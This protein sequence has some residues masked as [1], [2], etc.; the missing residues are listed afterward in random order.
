MATIDVE[1]LLA[2]VAS[3]PPCG[4][5]L[6]YDRAF[7]ELERQAAGKPERVMGDQVTPAEEPD[8]KQLG[9]GARALLERTKDLRVAAHLTKAL[10]RTGGLAGF[11]DGMRLV[12][13]LLERYWDGV[14]PR[15][16]PEDGD[17]TIRVNSLAALGDAPTV[18]AL[19]MAALVDA[20]G[21]GRFSLRDLLAATGELPLPAG[22][23]PADIAT[24]EAAFDAAELPDLA[25]TAA[26]VK[27]A[28]EDLAAVEAL[29][30]AKVGAAQAV[31]VAK[32]A[33]LLDQAHRHLSSRLERRAPAD[34]PTGN[35][36]AEAASNG[37]GAP[38]AGVA[39]QIRSREDVVRLIDLI[40]GYYQRAEPSSPVPLLL[41]RA[42]RLVT[43][44][45]VDI[46]KD[47]AP[48]AMP[49]IQMI[50]GNTDGEGS[51]Y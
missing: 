4:P 34:E 46:V 30:S 24:V 21:V 25:A 51:S 37:A 7:V 23:T 45:F 31:S 3:D 19:R 1:T 29:V 8:W 43:M 40:C 36:T 50:G 28:R 35:G 13:E 44:S 39:G 2:P 22:Q 49:R 20:R 42:K 6:E 32:L 33:T 26:A 15:L 11:A 41:N 14:H 38:R 9:L 12:R 27:G 48:D 47:M 5:N 17:P 18:A 16:D 10:L